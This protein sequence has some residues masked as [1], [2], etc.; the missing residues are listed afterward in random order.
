MLVIPISSKLYTVFSGL[1]ENKQMVFMAGLPG[2]G[3]SLLIQQLALLAKRAGRTVHLMQWDVSRNAFE[4]P[5][6]LAKYPEVDGVTDPLLRKAVGMWARGAITAWD[7][8]YAGGEH[9]LIGELPLIGNRL[10]ELVEQREDP[11]EGLLAAPSVEFVVP[12]PS[13]Q[14]R[15]VIEQAREQTIANPQ[16]EKEKMDAPPNVL[17]AMWDDVNELAERIDLPRSAADVGYDPAIYGGVY[18]ALLRHRHHT[19]VP[20]DEMLTPSGSVYESAVE[21]HLLE[22][23]PGE[24]RRAI[25][26]VE[27][28]MPR[29]ELEAAV[30][31]WHDLVIDG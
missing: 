12:V 27:G 10:S 19:L 11:C 16:H 4:T 13:K 1:A 6:V 26:A 20:V 7:R 29:A 31:N 9:L 23:T 2:V 21:T 22:A 24:V 8:A 14:V 30:E 3:K 18:A 17:R 25:A 15:S 28:S 5:E